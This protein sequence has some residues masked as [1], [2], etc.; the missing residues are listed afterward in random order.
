MIFFS[1]FVWTFKFKLKE[2]KQLNIIN[3]ITRAR[4]NRMY[5]VRIY[6]MSDYKQQ[7]TKKKMVFFLKLHATN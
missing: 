6:V 5:E 1:F 3:N 2:K 4:N 7:Q